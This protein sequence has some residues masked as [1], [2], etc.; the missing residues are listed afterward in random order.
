[1]TRLPAVVVHTC[2]PSIQETEAVGCV[3]GCVCVDCCI[4]HIIL[5]KGERGQAG[6][7]LCVFTVHA[8]ALFLSH[9]WG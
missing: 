4:A 9:P 1:M 5:L 8:P 7:W 3:C 2:D 6:L